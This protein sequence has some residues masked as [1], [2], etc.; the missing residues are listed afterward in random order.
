M[1]PSPASGA[2]RQLL[3]AQHR[4][5]QMLSHFP[6]A[7]AL[8]DKVHHSDLRARPAGRNQPLTASVPPLGGPSGQAG[9]CIAP[10]ASLASAAPWPSLAGAPGLQLHP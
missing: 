1:L 10:T 3:R 8:G 5:S 6:G 2:S 7:A 9:D 4:A